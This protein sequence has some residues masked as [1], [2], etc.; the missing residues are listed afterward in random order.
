MRC[1]KAMVFSKG[2]RWNAVTNGSCGSI[3]NELLRLR[4]S[5]A[6]ACRHKGKQLKFTALGIQA[7][8]KC[9]RDCPSSCFTRNAGSLNGRKNQGRSLAF[10]HWPDDQ[11]CSYQAAQCFIFLAP[12][13]FTHFRF[14]CFSIA[15]RS[16]HGAAGRLIDSCTD[17]RGGV[18]PS[19]CLDQEFLSGRG[20]SRSKGD[21]GLL[22]RGL[23]FPAPRYRSI[24]KTGRVKNAGARVQVPS[25]KANTP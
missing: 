13:S 7:W 10:A 22:A 21:R 16:G 19:G 17:C 1:R 8:T 9:L 2:S 11:E 25:R 3:Q 24:E 12:A 23:C 5:T 15:F 20:N 14:G 18:S 4:F 6:V